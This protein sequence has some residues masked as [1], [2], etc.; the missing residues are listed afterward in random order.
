MT[1]YSE[2]TDVDASGPSMATAL[3]ERFMSCM[4]LK[5]IPIS[6]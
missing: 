3:W 2:S 4:I 1:G 6:Y 5:I